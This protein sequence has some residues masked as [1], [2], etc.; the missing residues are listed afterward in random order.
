MR[1]KSNFHDYYDCI[2]ALGQDQS[3]IYIREP[4]CVLLNSKSIKSPF[5]IPHLSWRRGYTRKGELPTNS[6]FYVIGV[7]G[8]IY[9]VFQLIWD[10]SSSSLETIAFCY[11]LS[12][13]DKAIKNN[14]NKKAQ[15]SFTE[16]VKKRR[17]SFSG[18][19]KRD[20]FKK[21]FD[22]WESEDQSNKTKQ[23][24]CQHPIW[25]IEEKHDGWHITYNCSL[26]NFKFFRIKNAAET[27]QEISMFLGG[28]ATP[29]KPI[30]VPSDK[31]MVEIKG[32][33]KY[34]FRKDKK[35]K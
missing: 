29:Q 32:F 16:V 35:I 25:S 8:K 2:Q 15:E 27:F 28:L 9:P 3:L 7:A 21:F 23:F 31:D 1:I 6:K 13:I 30:P 10:Y 4:I 5:P 11:S 34:S 17:W 24:F 18:I 22:I 12:D 20:E 26:K 19:M 14:C 33:D